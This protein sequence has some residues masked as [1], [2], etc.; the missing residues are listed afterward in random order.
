MM[1]VL[2]VGAAGFLGEAVS[3]RLQS[4]GD[5][6]SRVVGSG[7]THG[8]TWVYRDGLYEQLEPLLSECSL[9]VYAAG[10]VLPRMH[11]PLNVAFERDCRPFN[12]LL[13]SL[14]RAKSHAKLLLLSTGGAVYGRRAHA[15]ACVETDETK[16]VSAYGLTRV[17]MEQS[18]QFHAAAHEFRPV[19]FRLSNVFGPG[20]RPEG[21]SSLVMRALS[22]VDGHGPLTLWGNGEQRKDFL[23]IDDVLSAIE[24]VRALPKSSRFS[25]P[26]F[27]IASGMSHSVL[28]VL[29]IVEKVTGR[30]VPVERAEA[31]TTDVPLVNLSPAKAAA[32][33][34]WKPAVSLASGVER[35]WRAIHGATT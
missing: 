28:D 19:V 32:E 25:D 17:F 10:S 26:R 18:L 11:T 7:T 21:G 14:G 31:P 8:T 33:L 34:K 29:R 4:L 5:E 2:V 24:A 3:R 20:Q 9:I 6:V 15:D 27:N 1:K 22:A 30:P 16:P 13:V 12:E 23:Y 35:F